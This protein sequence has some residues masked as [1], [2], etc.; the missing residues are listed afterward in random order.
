MSEV[1]TPVSG[2]IKFN[3]QVSD[4]LTQNV[5]PLL[6]EIKHALE[7]LI[8][9]GDTSIIDLRSIPLAPGEEDRILDTLGKGEVQA[10][11]ESLGLS[12]IIETQYAGVWVVTHYNDD[13]NI[14]S[15]FIEVTTMP[16]IL[17]S[18][19]EDVMAAYSSLTLDLDENQET[20]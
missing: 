4:E 10:K 13:G 6:H 1:A 3:I 5:K 11:L 16:S 15:R 12:E 8:E 20:I 17:S 2:E 14:I 9:N 7:S 18:Q 19:T